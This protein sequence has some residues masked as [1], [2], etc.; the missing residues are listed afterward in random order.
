MAE[1][2]IEAAQRLVKQY[3]TRDPF[4]IAKALDIEVLGRSDFVRQK[5]AFCTVLNR[6]FIFINDNMSDELKRIVCAHELGHALLHGKI[7]KAGLLE[8]EL[9]D[10]SSRLEYDANLFAATL[11]IDESDLKDC[12]L[13][14]Y[15][16]VQA[17]RALGTNANLVLIR[18][19]ELNMSGIRTGSKPKNDFL[20]TVQDNADF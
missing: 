18:L 6:K 16:A 20:G 11:L 15:D 19:G 13:N 3:A 9:F 17:A 1:K 14:G 2:P 7:A 4:A 10:V 5:G 8:F 12:I